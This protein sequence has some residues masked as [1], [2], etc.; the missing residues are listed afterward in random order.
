MTRVSRAAAADPLVLAVDV[1]STATR[2]DVYDAAGRPVAGGRCK[3]PHQFT[4]AADGTSQIDPNLVVE[5]VAQVIGK[6]ADRW[7]AGRIA[8]VALDT[9][10]SSLVGVRPDGGAV[11][12]CYTYADS[13]CAEQVAALRGNWTRR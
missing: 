5:E 6:L 1:G 3:V 8:A 4:T 13:R 7:R 10:A 12:P 2:G 9:F 11:T